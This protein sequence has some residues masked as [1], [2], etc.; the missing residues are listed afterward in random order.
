MRLPSG[1]FPGKPAARHERH[2]PRHNP[3][4]DEPRP[5]PGSARQQLP[6]DHPEE[7]TIRGALHKGTILVSQIRPTAK[8]GIYMFGE[9]SPDV[10]S[11]L[12]V[13]EGERLMDSMVIRAGDRI[14]VISYCFPV[15]DP[16]P[17]Q[18]V[19]TPLS[20]N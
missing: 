5:G 16:E 13:H 4:D 19:A 7:L 14:L 2:G 9:L 10:A 11:A 1:S 15:D 18:V 8:P 12:F 6:F 17:Y 3:V 20:V